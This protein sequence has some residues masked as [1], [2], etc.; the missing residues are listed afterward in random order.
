MGGIFGGGGDVPQ[1]VRESPIV[2]QAKIDADAAAKSQQES[3]ARKR[4]MRQ[5]SLLATAGSGDAS[6]VVTGQPAAQG[7]ATLGA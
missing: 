1:V 7:K 6:N 2:D 5:S 4:R 3:T